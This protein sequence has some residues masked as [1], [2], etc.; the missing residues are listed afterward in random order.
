[1]GTQQLRAVGDP[2]LDRLARKCQNGAIGT[3]PP[4][5]HNDSR[6]RVNVADQAGVGRSD[7]AASAAYDDEAPAPGRLAPWH[8]HSHPA[9]DCCS[10]IQAVIS[11]GVRSIHR[12]QGPGPE[13]RRTQELAAMGRARCCQPY[14][15]QQHLPAPARYAVVDGVPAEPQASRMCAIQHPIAPSQ[16]RHQLL[17]RR[18][19]PHPPTIARNWPGAATK[20]TVWGRCADLAQLVRDVTH[21]R[22][23][24]A[25]GRY[26]RLARS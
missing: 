20:R 13:H 21:G 19:G 25:P 16:V 15:R 1:M 14:A 26:G 12:R 4:R 5:G 7:R 22:P 6:G 3:H 8:H 10:E 23:G 9:V 11:T 24:G 2:P 18:S 17:V